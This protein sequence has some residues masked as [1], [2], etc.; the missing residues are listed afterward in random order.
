[1]S[2]FELAG[3]GLD[4]RMVGMRRPGTEASAPD[5]Q[6]DAVGALAAAGLGRVADV[7]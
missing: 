4:A 5:L 7:D 6:L 2:T 1:M 3:S